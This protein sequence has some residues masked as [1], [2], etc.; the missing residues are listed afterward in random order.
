MFDKF[1]R[2]DSSN[3]AIS[4]SGL[5]IHIVKNIVEAHNRTIWVKSEFGK[6]TTV[7]ITLPA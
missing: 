6:G 3:K 5:G 7:T 1:Y 2:T 4:G